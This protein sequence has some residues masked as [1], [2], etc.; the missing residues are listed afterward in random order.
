MHAWML[1][2]VRCLIQIEDKEKIIT[3]YN[4]SILGQSRPRPAR[5]WSFFL[6]NRHTF[7][8]KWLGCCDDRIPCVRWDSTKKKLHFLF[9]LFL[10]GHWLAIR[11]ISGSYWGRLMKVL[12][13]GCRYKHKHSTTQPTFHGWK[14]IFIAFITS[15][16]RRNLCF[17]QVEGKKKKKTRK[18]KLMIILWCDCERVAV[19]EKVRQSWDCSPALPI[20]NSD[21]PSSL[22]TIHYNTPYTRDFGLQQRDKIHLVANL[23]MPFFTLSSLFSIL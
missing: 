21:F 7:F 3:F 5:K 11:E 9:S 2:A 1:A 15:R 12:M 14:N 20:H 16:H 19:G 18:A 22:Y 6:T 10:Q 23:K 8:A 17:R 4:L 13:N